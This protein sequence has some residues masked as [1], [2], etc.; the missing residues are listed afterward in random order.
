MLGAGWA[1]REKLVP[2]KKKTERRE[3]AREK[4]AEIAA[5]L[6]DA[7]ESELLKRLQQ[8]RWEKDQPPELRRYRTH[9][10][11]GL[12]GPVTAAGIFLD[13]VSFTTVVRLQHGYS[14]TR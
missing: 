5:H 2:V 11:A 3:A 8:V 9:S 1:C 13:L 7:I 12:F 4:K 10:V 14:S 6:E